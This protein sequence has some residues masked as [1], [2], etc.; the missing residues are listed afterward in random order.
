MR[1]KVRAALASSALLLT[2][3]LAGAP[4]ASAALEGHDRAGKVKNTRAPK[5]RKRTARREVVYSCP[6]HADMQSRAP[7]ECA[8]CGM[9]LVASRRGAGAKPAAETEPEATGANR[10]R[11]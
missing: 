11:L 1:I 9:A 6:M 10:P 5:S 3:S 8:K 4:R 7:G 2:L